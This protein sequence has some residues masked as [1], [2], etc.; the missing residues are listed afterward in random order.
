MQWDLGCIL[1]VLSVLLGKVL[2]GTGGDKKKIHIGTYD[3]GLN[4]W[5]N[6]DTIY[7]AGQ[8]WV[9]QNAW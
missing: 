8:S 5:L 9:S 6:G 7:Y 3:Q 1:K 4:N 2:N